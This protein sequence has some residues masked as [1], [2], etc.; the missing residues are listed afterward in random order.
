MSYIISSNTLNELKQQE[1]FKLFQVGCLIC[2]ESDNT[3]SAFLGGNSGPANDT[4][5]P[6]LSGNLAYLA[7][8]YFWDFKLA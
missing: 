6:I 8:H 5:F 4:K 3:E 2:V 1:L 7:G